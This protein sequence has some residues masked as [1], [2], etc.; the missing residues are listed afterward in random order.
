[1]FVDVSFFEVEEGLGDLFERDFA[2]VVA[3]AREAE[4]CISSEL[5]RLD[6]E[7]R[8][9]WIERWASREEHNHFNQILFGMLLPERPD[10]ARFAHRL[11]ERDAEGYVVE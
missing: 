1:M 11:F 3:Q 8:Y 9:A 4:G 10:L 5:V 6:E 2:S 7:R